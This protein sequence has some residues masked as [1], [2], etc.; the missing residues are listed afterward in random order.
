MYVLFSV[1]NELLK[2]GRCSLEVVL[3]RIYM[4]HYVMTYNM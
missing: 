1:V 3:V 2:F 4:V